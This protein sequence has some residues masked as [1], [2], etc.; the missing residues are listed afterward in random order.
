MLRTKKG[1]PGKGSEKDRKEKIRNYPAKTPSRMTHQRQDLIQ[2]HV[3]QQTKQEQDPHPKG[4]PLA[5]YF[6]SAWVF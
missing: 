4:D 5:S 2:A 6:H 3:I 1:F